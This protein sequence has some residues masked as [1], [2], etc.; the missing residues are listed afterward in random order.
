MF[1]VRWYR[2]RCR[3]SD[4]LI[5]WVNYFPNRYDT[6]YTL[7]NVACPKCGHR[8]LRANEP[9]EEGWLNTYEYV[10]RDCKWKGYK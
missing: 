1:M 6:E 9:T 2:K 10:C 4:K 3:M 5:A 8:L 7:T